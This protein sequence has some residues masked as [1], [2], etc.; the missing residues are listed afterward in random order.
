MN[1]KKLANNMQMWYTIACC[2]EERD[3]PLVR[4]VLRT[5]NDEGG[6]T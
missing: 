5:S 1:V 6:H 4:K 2:E 3:G